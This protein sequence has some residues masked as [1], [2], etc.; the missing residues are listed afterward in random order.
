[1]GYLAGGMWYV[2]DHL[3]ALRVISSSSDI[4]RSLNTLSL[5][6]EEYYRDPFGVVSAFAM[7]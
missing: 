6:L 3:H 5:S 1:M 4:L 2:L 7:L